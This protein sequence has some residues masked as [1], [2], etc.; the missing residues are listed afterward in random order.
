[1]IINL[2]DEG[3]ITL[4]SAA[5]ARSGIALSD[6]STLD[7]VRVGSELVHHA[8]IELN[9][10]PDWAPE[11]PAGS[12]PVVGVVGGHFVR[13]HF[14]VVYDYP[15]REVRLYAPPKRN[16]K[17]ARAWLPP[18]FARRDCAPMV[19]VPSG[20]AT[21]TGVKMELDGHPVTGVLEMGPY[22]AKNE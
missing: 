18:G 20:A 5:L 3:D 11:R 10:R 21:F 7:T 6:T 17:A 22:Y 4:S 14:D 1:M 12:A 2:Q 19:D 15:A 16:D 8:P 9:H 13:T